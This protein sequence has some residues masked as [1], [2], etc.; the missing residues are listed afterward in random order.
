MTKNKNSCFIA[1]PQAGAQ[2]DCII[3][4]REIKELEL[5]LS[6]KQ[7]AEYII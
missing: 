6:C 7:D 1:K 5:K 2:G 3:I 4:F